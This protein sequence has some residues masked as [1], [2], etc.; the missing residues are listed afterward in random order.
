[1]RQKL[2]IEIE[3]GVAQNLQNQESCWDG[4]YLN[5]LSLS[6][7]FGNMN[8]LSRLLLELFELKQ[9]FSILS[10]WFLCSL[11]CWQVLLFVSITQSQFFDHV[12]GTDHNLV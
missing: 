2:G 7:S 4:L 11:S 9:S 8:S 1:M 3:T 6:L 12:Y 10:F 5:G